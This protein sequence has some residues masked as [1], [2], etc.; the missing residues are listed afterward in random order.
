MANP[1]TDG[2][3]TEIDLSQTV[4]DMARLQKAIVDMYRNLVVQSNSIAPQWRAFYRPVIYCTSTL[5]KSMT[6]LHE[7]RFMLIDRDILKVIPNDGILEVEE[8][9]DELSSDLYIRF[10]EVAA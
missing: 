2:E 10:L 3:M 7:G 5:A 9:D 1:L 8:G 4:M 6:F